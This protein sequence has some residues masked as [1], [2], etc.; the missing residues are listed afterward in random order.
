MPTNDIKENLDRARGG[1]RRAL[2]RV[3]EHTQP[4]LR[5]ITEQRL[6][7]ELRADVAPSDILQSTYLQIMRG[8][9]RFSG[10]SEDAFVA[11]VGAIVENN[12]RQ[13]KRFFGAR[14][15][16]APEG[17]EPPPRRLIQS[18]PSNAIRRIEDLLAVSRALERLPADYRQVILLKTCDGRS[19][20]D[21]AAIMQRSVSAVKMLLSRARAALTLAVEAGSEG[22]APTTAT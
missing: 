18:S 20:E 4:R 10:D 15:R 1:D 9:D 8:I 13:K 6:G 7:Q 5:R 12:I 14:K 16:K 21:I 22:G 3:I 11:W 2:D 17:L 19:H